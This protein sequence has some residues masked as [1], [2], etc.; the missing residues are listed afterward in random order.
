MALVLELGKGVAS[1]S[2]L[3][4]RAAL[5]SSTLEVPLGKVSE[6]TGLGNIFLVVGLGLGG[7][8][9]ANGGVLAGG[10]TAGNVRVGT[11]GSLLELSM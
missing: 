4:P 10:K 5:S 9:V 11:N 6:L 3:E 2:S 8:T 1:S 7:V